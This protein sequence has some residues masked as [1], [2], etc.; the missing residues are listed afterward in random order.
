MGGAASAGHEGRNGHGVGVM[1]REAVVERKTSETDVRL[2]LNLDGAGQLKV[3]TGVPFL[4]HMLTLFAAHGFV[5]LSLT[6]AGDTEIDDHHTVEDIG[7]CLG[8][9]LNKAFQDKK[10]IR[11]YGEAT[12]PM[13]EALARVVLDISNRPF[14]SYRVVLKKR[15]TGTFDVGLVKEFFRAVANHS[16]MTI[17]V[18]LLSGED[19]HHVSEAVFKAFAR[20][21]DRAKETE[22]RLKGSVPST[23]GVL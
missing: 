5:D 23:K 8:M 2:T 21:L 16:G 9:A 19:P 11:R 13:D 15:A 12:I 3:S 10:G 1:G 14:L 7:I 20:A 6:A 4:D 18:D 17:H 22:D